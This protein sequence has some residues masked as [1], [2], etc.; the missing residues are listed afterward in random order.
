MTKT[1]EEETKSGE[2]NTDANDAGLARESN[3][4]A[5]PIST[6]L[7]P[8]TTVP[9]P[10]FEQSALDAMLSNQ[11]NAGDTIKTRNLSPKPRHQRG[12]SWDLGIPEVPVD[13]NAS[14]NRET[15]KPPV[16]NRGV[17]VP[18]AA[19]GSGK[20]P[21]SGGKGNRFAVPKPTIGSRKTSNN[22]SSLGSVSSPIP[23]HQR[24]AALEKPSNVAMDAE[25]FL[26]EVNK[27]EVNAET[28]LL[29][30]LDRDPLRQRAETGASIL[31][32]V[33]MDEVEHNFVIEDR[34]GLVLSSPKSEDKDGSSSLAKHSH[35]KKPSERN[36]HRR[37]MT[38]EQTLFGL[39][40]AL[41]EMKA[42]DQMERGHHGKEESIGTHASKDLFDVAGAL[43]DRAHKKTVPVKEPVED[44]ND[45]SRPRLNSQESKPNLKR[46][47]TAGS[48]WG[49]IK[50]NLGEIKKSD[51]GNPNEM[52][53][54]NGDVEEG[55]QEGSDDVDMDYS[56]DTLEES[57]DDQRAGDGKKSRFS[58]IKGRKK[59]NPF[60]HLPYASKLF[61]VN[62][63]WIG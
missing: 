53:S 36:V 27:N 47:V 62:Q 49:A 50:D 4:D 34:D 10:Y 41:S 25:H 30:E 7:A 35:Q 3:V 31:T 16:V 57:S 11:G 1:S 33:P 55:I 45:A 51:E 2:G 12:V 42:Y 20:P 59:V 21:I 18:A 58:W 56:G 23:A 39:T 48:R 17:S 63:W 5:A 6:S 38:V 9:A 46:N 29:R 28:A 54:S 8:R 14:N 40:S 43:F 37:N 60:R 61:H 15:A 26:N 52:I 19:I 22:D 32:E 13:G 44:K 24:Y